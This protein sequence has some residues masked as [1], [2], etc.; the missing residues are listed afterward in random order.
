MSLQDKQFQFATEHK[1]YCKNPKCSGHG[2]VFRTKD[3]AM[4][5]CPNCNEWVFRDKKAELKYRLSERGVKI[6]N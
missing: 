6:D 5:L 1:V 2:V 4:K 3:Q